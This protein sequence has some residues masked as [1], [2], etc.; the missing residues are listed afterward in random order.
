MPLMDVTQELG[1]WYNINVIF[2]NKALMDMHIRYFC[3]RSETLE[4][5]ISLLNRMKKI[6]A[7]LSGNTL[8]IR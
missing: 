2:E 7:T 6:H 1:R 4:R 5:A 8:Y 3:V